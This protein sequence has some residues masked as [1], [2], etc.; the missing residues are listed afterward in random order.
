MENQRGNTQLI[1]RI[2]KWSGVCQN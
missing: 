1:K 2:Q